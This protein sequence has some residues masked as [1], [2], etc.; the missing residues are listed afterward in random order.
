MKSITENFYAAP[1]LEFESFH[2]AGNHFAVSATRRSY[3]NVIIQDAY[4]LNK[5]LVQKE[6]KRERKRKKERER[7]RDKA[8]YFTPPSRDCRQPRDQPGEPAASAEN[9]N[10][11]QLRGRREETPVPRPV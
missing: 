6:K 1:R 9:L 4:V 5:F 2:V 3:T 11:S 10:P 7:E 8:S